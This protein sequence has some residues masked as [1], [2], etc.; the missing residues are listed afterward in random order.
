MTYYIYATELGYPDVSDH[1]LDLSLFPG[2][3]LVEETEER[4]DLTNKR[5]VEGQWVAVRT[6]AEYAERRRKSYPALG[7]QMDM[8]WHAMD[9]GLIPKVEPMYSQIKAVKD[10]YPKP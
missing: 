8:L 1:P 9:D 10:K 4:P 7:D 5:R 6:E 3:L 2:Y